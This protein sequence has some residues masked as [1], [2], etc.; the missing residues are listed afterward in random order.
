MTDRVTLPPGHSAQVLY[1][2]G[3]PL[4][5]D[6]EPYSNRG[7]EPASEWDFRA[8]DHHDGMHF[9]GLSDGGEFDPN[10]SNR[11][12]LCINH[13]NITQFLMHE[14]AEVARGADGIREVDEVRKEMRA[15]GVSCI[16]VVRDPASGR[17]SVVRDSPY[18][19]RITAVYA[20]G[21]ARPGGR[22]RPGGNPLQPGRPG[23]F[24]A[25]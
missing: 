12:I 6:L 4:T 16:E 11:G 21:P 17:F 23:G 19:R 22:H 2:Y 20:H 18:N 13:E 24:A 7:T 1:A 8:G 9:F 14:M 25:P 15:H 10:A 5:S 3:D